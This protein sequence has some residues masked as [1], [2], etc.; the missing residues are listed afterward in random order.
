MNKFNSMLNAVSDKF[1]AIVKEDTGKD[2]ADVE[3][4]L[5]KNG[6]ELRI[7]DEDGYWEAATDFVEGQLR[8]VC[9]THSTAYG[10][11]L[12]ITA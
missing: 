11:K 10:L 3:R 12:E 2:V 6:L 5:T 4:L 1:A 7:Y 8:L 9:F